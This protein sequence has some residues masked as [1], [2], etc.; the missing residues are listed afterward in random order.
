VSSTFLGC[1]YS[2]TCLRWL[3]VDY[4]S[5]CQSCVN[6][7]S[8][9]QLHVYYPR[10][11]QVPPMSSATFCYPPAVGLLSLLLSPAS[12]SSVWVSTTRLC[13]LPL[14]SSTTPFINILR[15]YSVLF[16]LSSMSV[17]WTADTWAMLANAQFC[18]LGQWIPRDQ[19]WQWWPCIPKAC[20]PDG[21]DTQL[22]CEPYITYLRPCNL[23]NDSNLWPFGCVHGF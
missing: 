3:W 22:Y 23:D 2:P 7:F 12:L 15:K 14:L 17:L 10:K 4:L 5:L 13:Q 6:C 16:K 19:P 18:D 11:P 20:T 21:E 8:S 9:R 1:L